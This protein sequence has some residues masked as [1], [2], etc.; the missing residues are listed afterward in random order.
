MNAGEELYGDNCIS[1]HGLEAVSGG[2]TPDLRRTEAAVHGQFE[3]I[4]L[5][6]VRGSLGMPGFADRL[7]AEEVRAIQAYV[8]ERARASVGGY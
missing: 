6:G 3:N 7:N 5:G 2:I 8:L 1:C 4:V